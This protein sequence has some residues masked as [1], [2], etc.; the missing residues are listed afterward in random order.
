MNYTQVFIC[1]GLIGNC[2]WMPLFYALLPNKLE[3]TYT[4]LYNL[5]TMAMAAE[6][7]SFRDSIITMMDFELAERR[8][9]QQIHP[10]HEV[11]GC[12]FHYVQAVWRH[13]LTN[14]GSTLYENSPTIRGLVWMAFSLPLVPMDRLGEAVDLM[15]NE[16]R[17]DEWG[18]NFVENY[19]NDYWIR[20]PHRPEDWNVFE[21]DENLTNNAAEGGNNRLFTRMGRP[22]PNINTFLSHLKKEMDWAC[23][24]LRQAEHG[25]IEL[26][27]SRR[28]KQVIRTRRKLK[29]LLQE[30]AIDL[31]RY[32]RAAGACGAKV[33]E[34]A[35]LE[36]IAAD[37]GVYGCR[38]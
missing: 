22:H 21:M 23:S 31:R 24:K 8:P 38:I 7:V 25:L 28:T 3:V 4:R 10:S 20:G 17:N 18:Q 34:K 9:W 30:G 29:E 13:V 36:Q 37:Q 16:T 5:I 33:E 12:M 2:L 6:G 15:V 11:K 27:Q 19:I 1:Y 14:G 26:S 32:M 35:R